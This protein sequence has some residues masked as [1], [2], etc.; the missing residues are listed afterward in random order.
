M[1]NERKKFL[2]LLTRKERWHLSWRGWLALLVAI[3]VV[4]V[5]YVFN[6]YS[7]LAVN[8]PVQSD[9]LVV[10]GWIHNY[11]I[12]FA[13]AEFRNGNYRMAYS[14]GGPTAGSGGYINDFNTYASVGAELLIA[15]G[16]PKEQVQMVPSH[17]FG[18]DRTYTSAVVLKH[19][20]DE[21]DLHPA[22]VNVM[23]E[24][25]HAR[26]S[27]L[28]FQKALGPKIKVG[29]IPIP[30]PDYDPAHWWRYSEG[31]RDMLGETIAYVYAKFFF[32]P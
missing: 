9:V 3:V 27:W 24:D 12:K 11:A 4:K 21:H 30:N 6:V 5:V 29:V 18:R 31:V 22:A 28:L 14:T 25:A 16:I 7:F 2:G 26:R 8:A 1:P 19:W 32:H 13:V 10:E 15:D 23:T 20:F 17:E